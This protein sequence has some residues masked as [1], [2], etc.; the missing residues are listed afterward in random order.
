MEFNSIN[1]NFNIQPQAQQKAGLVQNAQNS[2][3]TPA[4][5][6]PQQQTQTQTTQNQCINP[7][8]M[9]DYQSAKMDNQTVL[10]YLQNL[11]NLP[12]S[13]EKFVNQLNSN[14]IDPK[15]KS[16]LIENM[17]S[18]KM[19]SEFLSQNSNNAISKLM[20]TISQNLKS[21]I[22]TSQLKEILSILG[23]IQNS[24]SPNS[25]TI[26]E[27]LLLYIPLNT[28]IFEKNSDSKIENQEEA[29]S[30]KNSKLSILFET[31]T[32]SNLLVC[33]DEAENNL[34]IDV[35]TPDNFPK[36]NFTKTV[37]ILSRE[38]SIIPIFNFKEKQTRNTESK[39]QNF[40]I[41][42]DSFIS[43]NTLLLAHIIIQTIL[44]LDRKLQ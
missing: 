30:V 9:F 40:K 17:I 42:S 10:K 11:M 24:N 36:S 18:V 22:D 20:Q 1:T 4:Q 25:N 28:P 14:N 13:I 37:E 2:Q 16:I 15:I 34:F 32:F 31:L 44:K 29:K 35:Y 8:L 3:N 33:I 26:K 12:N 21:G 7:A 6:Q 19:L 43:P 41:I 5:S 23:T 27:L 39:T 38:A